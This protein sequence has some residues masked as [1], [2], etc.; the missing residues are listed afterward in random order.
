[1]PSSD[2]LKLWVDFG[3]K[4]LCATLPVEKTHP[5]SSPAH[6]QIVAFTNFKEEKGGGAFAEGY[7]FSW[8]NEL[9]KKNIYLKWTIFKYIYIYYTLKPLSISQHVSFD[10]KPIWLTMI[11]SPMLEDHLRR[12]QLP[13]HSRSDQAFLVQPGIWG[14]QVRKEQLK[15]FEECGQSTS[16]FLN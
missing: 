6:E 10:R 1:M 4:F 5:M 2:L 7:R 3:V 12:E 15:L 11:Q 14:Q 9:W 8:R 16:K 13:S